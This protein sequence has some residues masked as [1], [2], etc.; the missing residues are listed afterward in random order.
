MTITPND[1]RGMAGWVIDQCVHRGGGIGGF[2]TGSLD[3]LVDYIEHPFTD[4][5]ADFRKLDIDITFT[6]FH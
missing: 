2:I 5:G 3:N 1:I 4:F 6:L